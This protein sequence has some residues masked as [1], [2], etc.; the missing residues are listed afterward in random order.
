M[1]FS[2]TAAYGFFD[3]HQMTRNIGLPGERGSCL[4]VIAVRIL[5]PL[6]GWASNEEVAGRGNGSCQRV[7]VA[8]TNASAAL[9][10]AAH[11]RHAGPTIPICLAEHRGGSCLHDV[12]YAGADL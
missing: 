6:T 12:V 5:L 7:A 3:I 11:D 10:S 2:N 4:R 8:L 9:G 1:R